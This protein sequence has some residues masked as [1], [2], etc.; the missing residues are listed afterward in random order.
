[1]EKLTKYKKKLNHTS[2]DEFFSKILKYYQ[3]LNNE[4]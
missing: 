3:Q 1:M 4:I 2:G